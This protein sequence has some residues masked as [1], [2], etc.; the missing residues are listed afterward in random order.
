MSHPELVSPGWDEERV[1][2]LMGTLSNRGRWGIDDQRGT[3]NFISPE[4]RT[5]ASREVRLGRSWSV[6][7]I[8]D[9]VGGPFNSHPARHRM[10]YYGADPISCGDSLDI[11]IHGMAS[12]HLDALGHEFFEGSLYNGR[13]AEHEISSV[14]LNW[15]NVLALS[16][17]IFTRGVL[18][19]V[20]AVRG[21]EWLEPTTRITDADLL[22]AE[23][24]SGTRVHTGDAIL[25]H[26]GY[27]R[28]V[29]AGALASPVVRAGI[30][31]ECL[32]WIRDRQVAVFSG[33]CIEQLPS[34][35]PRVPFPLH[36]IGLAAM[37]LV[38]LDSVK[39]DE[40]A[41]VCQDLGQFSFLFTAAPL[42][43][44]GGTGSPVNPICTF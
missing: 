26:S 4:T 44:P 29:Q 36:Q 15:A 3:L 30:G 34:P 32:P 38:L 25:V 13:R 40:L 28:A 17:G 5:A 31:P 42:L 20:C 37:G 19:D 11:D 18:L 41:T 9:T 10:H 14:G 35:Y 43:I 8:I 16:E 22:S 23:E 27:D 7:R 24:L 1:V 6:G 12:T 2:G 21:V 33:D 39:L